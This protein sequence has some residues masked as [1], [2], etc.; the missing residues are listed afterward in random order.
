MDY[1]EDGCHPRIGERNHGRGLGV[2]G[3]RGGA[4]IDVDVGRQ[5]PTCGRC[6][7]ADVL[8]GHLTD[9]PEEKHPLWIPLEDIGN[10]VGTVHVVPLQSL[11]Y[12]HV[13]RCW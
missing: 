9:L 10:H 4:T 11:I 13:S 5:A 6:V 1:A 7:T 2:G 3:G 12:G 8:I